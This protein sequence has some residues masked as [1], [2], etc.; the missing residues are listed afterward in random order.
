MP[1]MV[2]VIRGIDAALE[3][4]LTHQAI[5]QLLFAV[6]DLGAYRL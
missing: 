1:R 3:R 6:I 5:E 4:Q 2:S